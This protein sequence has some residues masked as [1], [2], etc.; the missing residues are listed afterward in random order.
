MI[1]VKEAAWKPQWSD[2]ESWCLRLAGSEILCY[3]ANNFGIA[4]LQ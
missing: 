2:D 1:A 4:I 3:K